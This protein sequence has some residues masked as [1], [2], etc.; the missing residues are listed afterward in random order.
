MQQELSQ[1]VDPSRH[2]PGLFLLLHT[3]KELRVVVA[4]HAATGTRRHH[5]RPRL[6]K[7]AQLGRGYGS[8]FIGIAR[9]I[10]RLT[11]A[12][13]CLRIKYLD[14]LAL[15]KTNTVE[16]GLR[17]KEINQASAEEIDLLRLRGVKPDWIELGWSHGASSLSARA[18][19]SCRAFCHGGKLVKPIF[20]N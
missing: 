6:G 1:L 11:T 19:H 10:S 12:G 5:D 7:Q 2:L 4:H 16:A 8:R 17:I 15:Q 18:R 20:L 3:S 13:L 9:G 14:P